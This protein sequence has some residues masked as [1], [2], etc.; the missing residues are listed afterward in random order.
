MATRRVLT[1][2]ENGRLG[3]KQ[4]ALNQN[5]DQREQRARAGGVAL[6][7][8]YGRNYYSFIGKLAGKHT[9]QKSAVENPLK[10]S[11]AAERIGRLRAA[12]AFGD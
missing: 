12:T 2:R 7:D 10:I 8:L 1:A 11:K 4:R 5:E 6:L 3:G 9:H